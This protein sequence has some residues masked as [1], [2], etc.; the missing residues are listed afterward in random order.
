MNGRIS[1]E[2][3]LIIDRKGSSLQV[4]CIYKRRCSHYC[5]YFSDPVKVPCSEWDSNKKL[6]EKW[7]LKLCKQTLKFDILIDERE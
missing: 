5:V 4:E 1:K 2:G 6:Q 7:E 3:I